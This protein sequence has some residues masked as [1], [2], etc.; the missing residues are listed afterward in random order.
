MSA[1]EDS[2]YFNRRVKL[3]E[4]RKRRDGRF[5]QFVDAI[6]GTVFSIG[7][8]IFA[9]RSSN[10]IWVHEWGARASQAQAYLPP[11]LNVWDGAGVMLQISPKPPY[12]YE[13]VKVHSSPYPRA[14]LPGTSFVRAQFGAHGPNH[15]FPNEATKGPDPTL[16]WAAAIQIFKSVANTVDLDITVGP[17]HYGNGASRAY[18]PQAPSDQIVD[19]TSDLPSAGMAVRV[20]IYLDRTTNKLVTVSSAEV[21]APGAPAFPPTPANGIASAY[22]YLEDT[23]TTIDMISDYIDARRWISEAD[24]TPAATVPGQQLFADSSLNWVP[25]KI[26]TSGGDVVISGGD[27]IWSPT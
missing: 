17:L 3:N 9:D 5:E 21:T 7:G 11:H 10:Y 24:S 27:V 8:S 26:V 14:V 15:Q 2:R 18:F 23:Y 13:I 20:L 22:F 4:A 25:G 19:L 6:P 12:E 1:L 16:I